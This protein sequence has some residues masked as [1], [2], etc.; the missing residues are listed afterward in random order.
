MPVKPPDVGAIL[1][2]LETQK[3]RCVLIGGLAMTVHGSAYMT[4]DIDFAFARGRQNVEAVT[5]AFAPFH[6]RPLDFPEGVPFVWDA[7]TVRAMAILTLATDRGRVDLLAEPEG[8]GSFEGL[9]ERS[10]EMELFGQRIRVASIPDLISMKE[11]A[12]RLKDQN[13]ILEL[14]AL[15]K[16]IEEQ[17]G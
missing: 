17:E 6:P 1:E 10:E 9:Y 8:A 3:V 12:G 15:L 13:H 7:Q 14:K 4:E 16:L 11:A 2:A 5:R